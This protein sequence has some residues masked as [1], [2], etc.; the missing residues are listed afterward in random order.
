MAVGI[1]PLELRVDRER[2]N[3]CAICAQVCPTQVIDVLDRKAVFSRREK[4]MGCQL[5][6]VECPVFAIQVRRP[7]LK[8]VSAEGAVPQVKPQVE[9]QVEPRRTGEPLI[10]GKPLSSYFRE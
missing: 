3:G 4:C 10:R 2:C 7:I 5:C 6:E 9:P 8:V 1:P